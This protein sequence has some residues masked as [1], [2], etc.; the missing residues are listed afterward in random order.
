MGIKVKR[1]K[2][3]PGGTYLGSKSKYQKD[4]KRLNREKP[5]RGVKGYNEG[6]CIRFCVCVLQGATGRGSE[7]GVNLD[8][9]REARKSPKS[10]EE[11]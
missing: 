5:S 4:V 10:G 3:R 8:L 1:D 2:E 6:V 7:L 11:S 9:W